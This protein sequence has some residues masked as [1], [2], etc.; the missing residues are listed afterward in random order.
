MAGST[1]TRFAQNALYVSLL[2]WV[3]AAVLVIQVGA[4][5]HTA[6]ASPLQLHGALQRDGNISI[7][8]HRGAA[9]LA[10]ENTL[11]AVRVAAEQRVDFV[12]V[13][14]R[15]TSDG[16]PILMHDQTV[17]RTTNGSGRVGHHTL[18]E[19]QALDAGAWFSPEYA[20]ERVP[21]LQEFIDELGSRPLGA[22]IELKGPWSSGQVEQ[23]VDTL[24]EH[25]LVNRVAL[26]SFETRK[27]ELLQELGPEF[28]RVMLTR[29]WDAEVTSRAVELQVSAIGARPKVFD[30]DPELLEK[31]RPLGIGL[32]AY[33]L[34]T[35]TL[36]DRADQQGVD[37]VV[38][39]D[40]EALNGWLTSEKGVGLLSSEGVLSSNQ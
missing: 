4:S 39:D 17:D 35:E 27:L 18:A 7:V 6:V 29:E 21:T 20:G 13:D 26:L 15:L 25:G 19:L 5:P 11:A 32:V 12:E 16:V 31:L 23:L 10:P 38:T 34:N 2:A 36:W 40:P 1:A 24:R 37:L 3:F 22:L 30:Q 9:A 8:S 33:T 28:A 14:L